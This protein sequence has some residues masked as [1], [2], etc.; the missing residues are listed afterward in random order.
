MNLQN[1]NNPPP[2]QQ[3]NLLEPESVPEV[4]PPQP[5]PQANNSSLLDLGE[6]EPSTRD[7]SMRSYQTSVSPSNPKGDNAYATTVMDNSSNQGSNIFDFIG[8]A[9]NTKNIVIPFVEVI[10]EGD[11]TRE[12]KYNGLS[13]K[14]AFQREGED[15]H[16]QLLFS[17]ANTLITMTVRHPLSRNSHSR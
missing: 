11:F 13:V 17:N 3:S 14:A 1:N 12:N 5:P 10:S 4:K 2:P 7:Q 6:S 9:K 15:I 16:L 8:T